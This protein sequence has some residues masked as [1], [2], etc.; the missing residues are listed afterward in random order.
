MVF[1]LASFLCFGGD[2]RASGLP[3]VRR[4]ESMYARLKSYSDTGMGPRGI[5]F[6]TVYEAPGKFYFWYSEGWYIC[7]NGRMGKELTHAGDLPVR[8]AD[9]KKGWLATAWVQGKV[10]TDLLEFEIAGFTGI[11]LATA[12]VVP[13][14]LFPSYA[15]RVFSRMPQWQL[16]PSE[17]YDGEMCYVVHSPD[18]DTTLWIS[19]SRLALRKES[20]SSLDG[21]HDVITYKPQ[22]NP[23]VDERVF[24]FKRP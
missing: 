18:E 12:Y 10:E 2:L 3:I 21:G 13:T 17:R 22:L 11:S 23:K 7:A 24:V 1:G 15:G 8:E 5:T 20:E 19:Q 4:M 14:M 9:R 16:L 6:K